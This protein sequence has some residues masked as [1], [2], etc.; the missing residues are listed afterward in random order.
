[1]SI[2]TN[3]ALLGWFVYLTEIKDAEG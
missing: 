3:N 1:M 2:S